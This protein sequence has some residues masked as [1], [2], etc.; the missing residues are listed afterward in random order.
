MKHVFAWL[1]A[2]AL[3]PPQPIFAEGTDMTQDQEAALAAVHEMTQAFQ[4]KNIDRVMTSYEPTATVVFEPKSPISDRAQI[5]AMFVGMASVSPVFTYA[6]G[7]EIIVNGD[8]AMHIAPWE[9]T[10]SAPDGQEINQSGLSVAIL[11]KQSDGRWTIV[12][13]NPHGGALLLQH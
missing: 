7:H 13:D 3:T 12:I 8:L 4:N 9:M 5:E 2:C 10:G 1:I 11:R 6:S